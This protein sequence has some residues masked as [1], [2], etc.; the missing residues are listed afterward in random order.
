VFDLV[1]RRKL[2]RGHDDGFSRAIEIVATPLLFGFLGSLA[3]GWLGTRPAF[4]IALGTFGAVGLFVKIW[5]RYDR[6]MQEEQAAL[7][8]RRGIVVTPAPVEP[9]TSIM[10]PRGTANLPGPARGGAT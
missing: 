2:N 6:Q 5:L 3:D 1:A 9:D 8:A 10:V 7:P 4:M